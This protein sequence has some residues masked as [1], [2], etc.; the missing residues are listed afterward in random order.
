MIV[1]LDNFQE[2][3]WSILHWLGEDL[4]EVPIVVIVHQD[5]QFL[6]NVPKEDDDKIEF[7]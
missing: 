4:Q 1:T 3:G 6:R 5:F 2:E 7:Q